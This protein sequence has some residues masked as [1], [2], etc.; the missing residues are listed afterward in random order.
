MLN[1]GKEIDNKANIIH[2]LNVKLE[3]NII[4]CEYYKSNI[5]KTWSRLRITKLNLN[6]LSYLYVN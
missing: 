5:E 1:H 4:I 6:D 3:D 2:Y